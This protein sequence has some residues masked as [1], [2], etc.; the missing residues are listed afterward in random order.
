MPIQRQPRAKGGQ[1]NSSVLTEPFDHLIQHIKQ[2][3]VRLYEALKRLFSLQTNITNLIGTDE[4]PDLF[5][6]VRDPEKIR[7][8]IPGLAIVANDVAVNRY[9]VKIDEDKK[10]LL[11]LCAVTA[12]SSPPL[13]GDYEVDWLRSNNLSVTFASLFPAG[14][15]PVLPLGAHT[16]E[17]KSF[18]II[19][20]F[21]NDELRVDVISA[22]GA[23]DMETVL[24]GKIVDK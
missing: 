1:S 12:K 15:R 4:E 5:P 20:L 8:I 3:D 17:H 23:N 11:E 14:D 13:T 21:N 16:M 22:E 18:A 2:N 9:K 10:I 24:K 6:P 19:E 7:A